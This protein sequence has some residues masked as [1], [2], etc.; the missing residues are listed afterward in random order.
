M[1]ERRY[2]LRGEIDLNNASRLRADLKHEVAEQNAVLLVDCSQLTFIDSHGIAVLLEAHR[3]V[4]AG[5]GH[6]LLVDV[7][8]GPRQVFEALGLSDLIR[9]NGSAKNGSAESH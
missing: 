3:N 5:G 1:A 8:E 6:L 2:C 7:Q 4:E 9:V